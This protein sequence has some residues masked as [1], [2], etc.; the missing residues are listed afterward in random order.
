MHWGVDRACEDVSAPLLQQTGGFLRRI[1][2]EVSNVDIG[3]LC[4]GD[5]KAG[6]ATEI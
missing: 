4:H 6:V 5:V 2:D 1:L 3:Q